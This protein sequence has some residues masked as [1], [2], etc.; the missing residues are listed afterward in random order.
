MSAEPSWMKA[1][2]VMVNNRLSR[3]VTITCKNCHVDFK[4]S[5]YYKDRKKYCSQTCF[6]QSQRLNKYL[7]CEVCGSSYYRAP[8]QVK[9]RGSSY[10]S[11]KCRSVG[12]GL[13]YRGENSTNWKGG[14]TAVN[15]ILRGRKEFK[16]WRKKIFLRDNFTCQNCGRRGGWLEA[17]HIKSFA[18]HHELRYDIN[19]GQTLC[20]PCHAKT[21]NYGTKA[22]QYAS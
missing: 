22:W 16:E 21:D 4:V 9:W 20:K 3:Q 2:R 11:I 6:T 18:H 10:C 15:E 19:N 12:Q 1:N 13:K 7:K 14:V 5:P 8:S 17:H